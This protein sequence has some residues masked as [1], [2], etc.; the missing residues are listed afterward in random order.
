MSYLR[1]PF[2][3]VA[4][5]VVGILGTT[6]VAHA[7]CVTNSATSGPL[8][9]PAGCI[10]NSGTILGG[11]I[12]LAISPGGGSIVNS[13][14]VVASGG[15][16]P[17]GT[18]A[19]LVGGNGSIV[20]SGTVDAAAAIN[21]TARGL[22]L[23]GSGSITNSGAVSATAGTVA[24]ILLDGGGGS[25]ANSGTVSA[26]AVFT[27]SAVTLFG[28]D[29]ANTGA[30]TA[31][32]SGGFGG[33]ARALYLLGSGN[34]SNAG[35][36]TASASVAGSTGAASAVLI[37]G[38]GNITNTGR[39]VATTGPDGTA[40][41][42][43]VTGSGSIFN[44]G[45]AI[46]TV[47]SGGTADAISFGAGS[48]TLGIG[49]GSF[50]IG[51]I[52]FNGANNAVIMNV[53]NQNLTF[54]TLA[55]ATVT[56]SVPLIVSGNRIVSVDPTSFA[57][58][59]RALT[60]F[61]REVTSAIPQ[62]TGSAAA[63]GGA[64]LAFAGPETSSR[65]ADAFAQIPGLAAY[66]GGSMAFKN[67]TVVYADGSAM[68]GRGFAGQ[69]IQ[70][71]DG[72]QQRAA[73]LFYGGMIGGDMRLRPDLRVGA[74]FGMGS[75]HTSVDFS[76]GNSSSDLVFGGGYVHYDAGATFL[77]AAL[78]AGGSRNA[79]TRSI[80]NNLVA[81]GLETANAGF[82]GWYVSP[83]VTIGHRFALGRTLDASYT[84]TPSFRLRYLYGAYDGYTET[85]TTNAPLTVGGRSVGTLEE[86]GEIKLTR[87]VTFRPDDQL[88]TSAYG[89]L[90]GTQRAGDGAI[91]A[92]ALGQVLP[93]A[94]TGPANVWGG[95]GGLG[96]EWRTRRVTMF[97]TGE[98]LALSDRSS[99]V[100]G[101]A[102]LRVAF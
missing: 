64:P 56:G 78:Q 92:A 63:A 87:T 17:S 20:N 18:F 12:G 97:S 47:G 62:M 82:N 32:A 51:N 1:R 46:A 84:L 79:N 75:S 101:R 58:Q 66:S 14:T 73:N 60:D 88:S 53:G 99:V 98:Y 74:F 100:S 94:A 54:N 43:Q 102:G 27:A 33:V 21:R 85:G 29:I 55:S 5:P 65:I 31:S 10:D 40:N 8:T 19:V 49:P 23:H 15:S 96:L 42:L 16:G 95:F 81:G 61:T 6:S 83:E 91:N 71:A 44:T 57:M 39:A 30:V 28:G 35:T 70:Q 3:F 7:Q 93:F 80:N 48:S 86:R 67:P 25:I 2:S 68:W 76:L 50:V 13:G 36:A 41:A 52:V 77:R 90:L 9:V 24:A 38:D 34:I 45:A 37:D 4:L 11:V 72:P 89:G 26:S 69:R 59:G 22:F